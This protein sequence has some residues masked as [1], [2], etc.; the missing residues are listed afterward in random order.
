MTK[1]PVKTIYVRGEIVPSVCQRG[2]AQG[3]SATAS[4]GSRGEPI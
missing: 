3:A 2:E 4:G 1:E